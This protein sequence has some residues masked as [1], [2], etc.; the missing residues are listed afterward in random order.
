MKSPGQQGIDTLRLSESARKELLARLNTKAS[1]AGSEGRRTDRVVYEPISGVICR[2]VHPGGTT[3]NCLIQPRNLSSGGMSYLHGS[4]VHVGSRCELVLPTIKRQA[5]L[6]AAAV[7]WCRHVCGWVHEVGVHFDQPLA[8]N[9]FVKST[10]PEP[11][12]ADPVWTALDGRLLYVEDSADER[13]LVKFHFQSRGVGIITAADGLDALELNESHP[14][15]TIMTSS[16]LLGIS[17]AEL[18]GALRAAGFTKPIIVLNADAS[19][20]ARVQAITSGATAVLDKP[21]DFEDLLKC[22]AAN[23]A[24]VHNNPAQEA[25]TSQHWAN[26]PMRPLILGFLERLDHHVAQLADLA[27]D[28]ENWA[29]VQ[30]LCLDLRASAGGYGFPQISAAARDLYDSLAQRV[31]VEVAQDLK[32]L[33]SLCRSACS[34]RDTPPAT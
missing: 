31:N 21:Y 12:P 14:L 2:L 25:L 32:E 27:K 28:Q 5:M 9:T 11:P 23:L 22:L 20:E 30:K 13:D 24:L 26:V 18:V 34:I 4:F 10:T 15:E 7:V 19:D 16:T 17:G 1:S 8:L 6:V 33:A 29:I 3:S